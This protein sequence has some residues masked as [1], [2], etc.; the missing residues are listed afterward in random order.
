MQN[1]VDPLV[2]LIFLFSVYIQFFWKCNPR[3]RLF[4][5]AT[6]G[7]FFSSNL[8]WRNYFLCDINIQVDEVKK[9][10]PLFFFKWMKSTKIYVTVIISLWIF[11]S[12]W[13]NVYLLIKCKKEQF[14]E[15]SFSLS[16]I[17]II[18]LTDCGWN[19]LLFDLL[20]G[21]GVSKIF[22]VISFRDYLNHYFSS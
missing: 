7:I 1:I 5:L 14:A 22:S 13:L 12:L 17:I 21:R 4:R 3:V 16:I 15:L 19:N 2:Y 9:K 11:T 10:F 8:L 18:L 20:N 6:L